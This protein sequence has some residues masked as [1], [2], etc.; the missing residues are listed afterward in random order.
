MSPTRP[1]LWRSARLQQRNM[2]PSTRA[3]ANSNHPVPSR[4]GQA[5]VDQPSRGRS[6]RG[7]TLANPTIS[8]SR[9]VPPTSTPVTSNQPNQNINIGWNTHQ[10]DLLVGW[11]TSHPA[12]CNILFNKDNKQKDD[13]ID[14]PSGKD[15]NTIHEVIANH[16]FSNDSQ[17]AATYDSLPAKFSTSVSNRI[18]YLRKKFLN[19]RTELNQ[20]GQGVTPADNTDNPTAL[21]TKEFPWYNDLLSIWNGMPNFTPKVVTSRA[22]IPRGVNHL[23]LIGSHGK[24]KGTTAAIPSGATTIDMHDTAAAGTSDP[25]ATGTSD[26]ATD[27]TNNAAMDLDFAMGPDQ[28]PYGD[29]NM[30]DDQGG[31]QFDDEQFDDEDM[32]VE[33]SGGQTPGKRKALELDDS[34]PGSHASSLASPQ[35]LRKRSQSTHAL[36]TPPHKRIPRHLALHLHACL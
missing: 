36:L 9:T 8:T 19:Q 26:P 22:G 17:W 5:P 23:E 33:P 31:F 32:S 34:P 12:D 15:K 1:C 3:R 7:K 35:W 29:S 2:A 4:R 14:K 24:G 28:E 27:D 10:T 6:R 11:L 21:A 20:T 18:N 16:I 30:M 13:A 25:A